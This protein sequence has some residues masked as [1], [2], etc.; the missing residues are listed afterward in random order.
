[1]SLCCR[2]EIIAGGSAAW[3]NRRHC[4]RFCWLQRQETFYDLHVKDLVVAVCEDVIAIG[5][6]LF[7][8]SR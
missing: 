8:V 7:F 2:G 4:R 3:W 1:M 6:A 5:L